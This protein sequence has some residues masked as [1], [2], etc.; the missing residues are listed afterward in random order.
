MATIKDKVK[1]ALGSYF[2]TIWW[3]AR[4]VLIVAGI[5]VCFSLINTPSTLT[6]ILGVF[7]LGVI[8]TYIIRLVNSE[9][10][11]IDTKEMKE[12]ESK[13]ANDETVK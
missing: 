9:I 2:D 5:I 4:L 12:G 6:V 11:K 8:G 13:D 10:K 7:G 1:E 3:I